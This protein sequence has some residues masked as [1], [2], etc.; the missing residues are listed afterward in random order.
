M[1]ALPNLPALY[2]MACL[3]ALLALGCAF[4]WLK[5]HGAPCGCQLD[6]YGFVAYENCPFVKTCDQH[7]IGGKR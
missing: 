4:V 5:K 2:Y 3:A 6:G 7:C 1:H